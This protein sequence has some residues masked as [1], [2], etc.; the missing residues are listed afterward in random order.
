MAARPA[1]FSPIMHLLIFTLMQFWVYFDRGALSQ[2]MSEIGSS[3]NVTEAQLGTLGSSFTAGYMVASPIVAILGQKSTFAPMYCIGVGLL[4][5]CVGNVAFSQLAEPP[6]VNGYP[7]FDNSLW[8]PMLI[9]RAATGVGEAGFVCLGPP[10]IDDTAPPKSKGFY[11][12]IYFMFIF[13]GQAMGYV[14][15]G[16]AQGTWPQWPQLKNVFL[17]EGIVMLP[18]AVLCVVTA[19]KFRVEGSQAEDETPFVDGVQAT[20]SAGSASSRR[21]S[22]TSYSDVE[23]NATREGGTL[24]RAVS[25]GGRR[26]SSLFQDL[27]SL[28]TNGLFVTLIFGYSAYQFVMGGVAYWG[29]YYVQ[30]A[31]YMSASTSGY[32]SGGVTLI[33]GVFGTFAGSKLLDRMVGVEDQEPGS[34]RRLVA[35]CKVMFWGSILAWP[36]LLGASFS[37]SQGAFFICLLLGQL[38]LFAMYTSICVG[39][40]EAVPESMRGTAMAL[41][42]LAIHLLGDIPSQS[43]V[44][45]I[46]DSVSEGATSGPQKAKAMQVALI[47]LGSFHIVTILLFT[48]SYGLSR[49]LAH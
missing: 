5:W 28:F 6:V 9:S 27:L 25:D 12:G 16:V 19:K 1:K 42:A 20:N 39:L 2:V 26:P 23:V 46:A 44:G 13:V 15:G 37:K 31:L 34:N 40:M 7:V 41:S 3:H 22:A 49:R 21:R 17:I 43:L 36:F 14:I 32:A 45:I 11:L 30:K 35:G 29:P 47:C 4:V 10:I 18:M 33:S 8:V 48:L 38:P 24:A